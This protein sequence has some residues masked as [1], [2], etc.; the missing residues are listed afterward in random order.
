[1]KMKKTFSGRNSKEALYRCFF[2]VVQL[3]EGRKEI[4]DN[5]MSSVTQKYWLGLIVNSIAHG[6]YGDINAWRT[7]VCLFLLL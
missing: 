3:V 6:D 7:R 4:L 5:M 2:L 1:M